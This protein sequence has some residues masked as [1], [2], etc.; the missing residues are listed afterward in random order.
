MLIAVVVVFALLWGPLFGYMMVKSLDHIWLN[1]QLGLGVVDDN[2]LQV[3]LN[4]LSI[5]NSVMNPVL[6]ALLSR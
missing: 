6:Y 1:R 2:L 4:V 5:Y 3:I